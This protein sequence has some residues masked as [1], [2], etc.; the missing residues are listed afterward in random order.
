MRDFT[1]NKYEQLPEVLL[2]RKDQEKTESK[3]KFI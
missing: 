1:K 2:R 3:L